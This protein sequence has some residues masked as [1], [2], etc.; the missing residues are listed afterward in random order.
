MTTYSLELN[1]LPCYKWYIDYKQHNILG[2]I[3]PFIILLKLAPFPL[4]IDLECVLLVNKE[5][6][7]QSC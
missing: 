3:K 2:K 1:F 7:M 4:T 6:F 5:A